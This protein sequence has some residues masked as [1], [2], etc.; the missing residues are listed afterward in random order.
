MSDQPSLFDWTPRVPAAEPRPTAVLAFPLHRRAD[1][2]RRHAAKISDF[3]MK[4]VDEYLSRILTR[5]RTV[6]LS[7]G[8]SESVA[9]HEIYLVRL[10]IIRAARCGDGGSGRSSIG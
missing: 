2:V 9:D 4:K 3:E 10:A 6:L 5:Q 8:I 7:K 1:F